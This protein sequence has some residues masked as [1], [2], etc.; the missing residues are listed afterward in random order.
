MRREWLQWFGLL[1]APLAWTGQHLLGYGFVEGACN[2]D[3]AL[4][5]ID[6]RSWEVGVTAVAVAV[7]L[8]AELAAVALFLDTRGLGD[9]DPPLGRLHFFAAGSMAVGVIFLGVILMSG[10]G[11]AYIAGCGQG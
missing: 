4:W 7:A 9:S 11:V 5:G 10:I 1:G 3:G 8:A 6:P 2:G